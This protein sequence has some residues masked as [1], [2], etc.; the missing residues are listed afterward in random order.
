M[1]TRRSLFLSNSRPSL[2]ESLTIFCLKICAWVAILLMTVIMV[3]LAYEASFFFWEVSL[4]EFFSGAPWNPMIQ[5]TSFGIWPLVC[6][7][8][9]VAL[10]ASLVGMPIGLG[11][12][13]YLSEYASRRTR[14][15][16]K[17]TME[18]LA[19]IP[20]VVFGFVALLF[21]TPV[22]RVIWP[23]AEVFNALSASLVVGLMVLPMVA[24]VSD[25][26][27][28]SVSEATKLGGYA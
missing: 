22:I 21:V 1:Q 5:P 8:V 11:V 4:L 16:L 19:G 24:S 28:R 25:D 27:L 9:L 3:V 26:A 13:I 14:M 18:L 23:S 17:P 2:R 7:T 20:S 6:G 12:A 10:G 15:W